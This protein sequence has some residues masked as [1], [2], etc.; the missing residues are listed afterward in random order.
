MT[1]SAFTL[2]DARR[3]LY[4]LAHEDGEL[5]NIRGRLRARMD[6]AKLQAQR[7]RFWR[8]V[9]STRAIESEWSLMQKRL[10]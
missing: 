8:G 4:R 7:D 2:T 9:Q 10:R 3:A 5:L 6:A 1:D